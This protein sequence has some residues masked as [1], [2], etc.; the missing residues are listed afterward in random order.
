[1]PTHNARREVEGPIPHLEPIIKA[2]TIC[3]PAEVEGI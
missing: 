1:M 3:E 2:N